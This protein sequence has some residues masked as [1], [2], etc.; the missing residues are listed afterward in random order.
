MTDMKVVELFA[1]VGGFRIGLEKADSDFFK[2]IWSNQFEPA[3]KTQHASRTYVRA[4][5]EDGHVNEDIA[6]VKT[7]DIPDHDML[8]GGF[9][10]QDYSVANTLSRS[11]GIV[12][13]K[14]VLWWEIYRILNEKGDKAPK[15]LF[16]ENVDRLIQSPSTQRGRDFAIILS[17]LNGLGYDVEWRVINAAEYGMPQRRRRTY[18]VAYK[19]DNVSVDSVDVITTSGVM[20]KAFPVGFDVEKL[21]TF[22]IEPDLTILSEEFNYGNKYK[23]FENAGYVHNGMCTTCK[24]TSNYSGP[25]TTLGDVVL[26]E[27][28]SDLRDTITEDYYLSDEDVKKWEYSKGY[29]RIEKIN[30]FGGKYMYSEGAM[31]FPDPL[32]KPSRTIITS[33][34]TKSAN[35]FTHII[36]DPVNGRYRRLVPVELERLNMF[37]DNH[38]AGETDS[39]RGFFMG[40]ALVCGVVEK[41]GKIIKEKFGN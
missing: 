29:K 36:Q 18:I 5:G 8:V 10:C 26:T 40:N 11:K 19:N 24:V 6:K 15:V 39:K 2:T 4:F 20:A 17:S 14:G 12:G 25:Y 3:T 37:P 7:I 31:S 22:N 9:P 23:M 41:V 1:G 32:D 33:E 35:R 34:M 28:D 21:N 30:K 13:K 16:F 38:T 27:K